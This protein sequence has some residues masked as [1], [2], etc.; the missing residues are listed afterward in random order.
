MSNIFQFNNKLIATVTGTGIDILN[1]MGY[2]LKAQIHMYIYC[3]VTISIQF[4][5]L[6]NGWFLVAGYF[7]CGNICGMNLSRI[8]LRYNIT[9]EQSASTSIP[10]L[11]I[12]SFHY[13]VLQ[14]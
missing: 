8:F 4:M 10:Y 2:I 5:S 6:T 7:K 11:F 1:V 14:A 3:I 9:K 12:I 13:N